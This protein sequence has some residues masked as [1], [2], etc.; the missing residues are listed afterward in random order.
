MQG[1]LGLSLTE[2]NVGKIWRKTPLILGKGHAICKNFFVGVLPQRVFPSNRTGSAIRE[3]RA[4]IDRAYRLIKV[5]DTI[6]DT[7]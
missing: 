5:L 3:K 6:G 2:K 7:R 1:K 4:V